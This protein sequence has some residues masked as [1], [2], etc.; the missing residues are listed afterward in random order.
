MVTQPLAARVHGLASYM[1]RIVMEACT[2]PADHR[3]RFAERTDLSVTLAPMEH[4]HWGSLDTVTIPR[5]ASGQQ[6]RRLPL[7]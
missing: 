5:T 4:S 3:R 6:S 1:V 7:V 2:P